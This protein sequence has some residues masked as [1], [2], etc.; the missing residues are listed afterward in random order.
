MFLGL[1]SSSSYGIIYISY[2]SMGAKPPTF[3]FD[4]LPDIFSL[5]AV[6]YHLAKPSYSESFHG[7]LA[8]KF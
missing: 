7:H 1:A 8:L 4:L 6:P 5:S 3:L 2:G